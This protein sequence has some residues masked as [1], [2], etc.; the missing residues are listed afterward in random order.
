MAMSTAIGIP[1][2]TAAACYDPQQM[3]TAVAD[4]FESLG[5]PTRAKNDDGA[6]NPMEN[7]WY[8]TVDD[9]LVYGGTTITAVGGT[10]VV[11]TVNGSH[12]ASLDAD[13]ATNKVRVISGTEASATPTFVN[14]FGL[15][16]S[17]GDRILGWKRVSDGKYET[18][19][20][21]GGAG[22]TYT[23]GD[24]VSI[25]GSNVILV[26]QNDGLE[27]NSN[28]LE[29]ALNATGGLEFT[30][31]PGT[32]RNKSRFQLVKG[33]TTHVSHPSDGTINIDNVSA[34]RGQV[35]DLTST[36]GNLTATTTQNIWLDNNELVYAIYNEDSGSGETDS[37]DV[38][39]AHNLEALLRGIADYDE[40]TNYRQCV[41][42]EDGTS[43]WT[44][45]GWIAKGQADGPMESGGTHTLNNV[46]AMQGPNDLSDAIVVNNEIG[47]ETD[48]G[49]IVWAMMPWD[50]STWYVFQ[51]ECPA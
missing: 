7:V 11:A 31:T 15:A 40:T 45:L 16:Y 1:T 17:H 51:A 32:I 37:W 22:G 41:S 48:S 19:S 6:L 5:N 47:F 50:S 49:G 21:G 46:V 27:I 2:F 25:T 42:H 9:D 44:G 43:T 38:S 13:I 20:Y 33:L 12:S 24:G 30:G 35:P 4:L 39:T 28:Q 8:D 36:G 3:S 14:T 23:G 10:S 34:V 26:D 18:E 29:V